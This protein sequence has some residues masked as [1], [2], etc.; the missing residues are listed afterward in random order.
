MLHTLE[1]PDA[2][3][4]SRPP[5]VESGVRDGLAR[6]LAGGWPTRNR[7]VTAECERLG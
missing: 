3:A 5:M 1:R 6:V 7:T 2:Y 4:L